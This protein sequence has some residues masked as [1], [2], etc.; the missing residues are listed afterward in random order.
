MYAQDWKA[1]R[2]G[3][4]ALVAKRPEDATLHEMLG[5]VLLALGESRRAIAEYERAIVLGTINRGLGTM[6]IVT[7]YARLGET[8]MAIGW[9]EK[10][11]PVLRFFAAR[12]RQDPLF[13]TL[14]ADPRVVRLLATVP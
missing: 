5:E 9:I 11:G 10:M 13:A 1:A 3:Y 2:T 8:E 12:L 7:A 6:A 4:E 14:R